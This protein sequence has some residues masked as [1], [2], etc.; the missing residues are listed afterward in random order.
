MQCQWTDDQNT[1]DVDVTPLE[2]RRIHFQTH[3]QGYMEMYSDPETIATYLQAHEGWFCRCAEPMK[4]EAIGD[5]GY[6]LTVGRFGALGY[7]VEPKMAVVLDPPDE[8]VYNMRSIPLED[9][10]DLGYEVDYHAAMVLE[11]IP[12]ETA[13]KGLEKAYQK[14]GINELPENITRVEWQ[15]DMDVAVQFPKFIYRLPLSVIQSTGDRLMA[16]IVRQVSPRLSFKV[17]QDF[18]RLHDLP[19]PPKTSRGLSKIEPETEEEN[20]IA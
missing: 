3:F 12:R 18:H 4:T 20:P 2:E 16:Q 9:E 7:D 6:I 13:G 5:N 15:L 14:E 10:P 1:Q 17:Q 8:G 19:L 11:E